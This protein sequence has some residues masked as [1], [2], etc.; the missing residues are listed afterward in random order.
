MTVDYV[1]N[2]GISATSALLVYLGGSD[3]ERLEKTWK[4]KMEG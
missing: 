4:E 3:V 1:P 2:P